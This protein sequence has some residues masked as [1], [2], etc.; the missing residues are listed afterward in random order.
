[1]RQEES[2]NIQNSG[3][4]ILNF[5][6]NDMLD[7]AQLSAGNFRKSITEFNLLESIHEVIEVMRYKADELGIEFNMNFDYFD[8]QP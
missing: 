8:L 6:V 7:Y 2:T 4:K 5:L 3:V 1:M